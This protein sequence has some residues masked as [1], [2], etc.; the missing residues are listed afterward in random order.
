[1]PVHNDLLR[2]RVGERLRAARRNNNLSQKELGQLIGTS[3][4]QVLKYEKAM[5]VPSLSRLVQLSAVLNTPL[6]FFIEDHYITKDSIIT[7]VG[8]ILHVLMQAYGMLNQNNRM[9]LLSIAEALV[10]CSSADRARGPEKPA[11]SLEA[12]VDGVRGPAT[13]S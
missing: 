8:A 9:L 11:R 12:L 4:Q 6:S 13:S 5:D 2:Q 7:G 10:E 1:M 3:A